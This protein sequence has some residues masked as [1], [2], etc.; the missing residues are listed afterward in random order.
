M[1]KITNDVSGTGCFIAV[2]CTHMATVTGV[3]GPRLFTARR[4]NARG[5][6]MDREEARLT[7]TVI[8]YS[9]DGRI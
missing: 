5:N 6:G 2:P 1:S 7:Q 3:K 8:A 9:T 4:T